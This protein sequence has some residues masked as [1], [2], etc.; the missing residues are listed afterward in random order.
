MAKYADI[1]GNY[2]EPKFA[3]IDVWKKLHPSL[4]FALLL[5]YKDIR[6]KSNKNNINMTKESL[7]TMKKD[8]YLSLEFSEDATME[9]SLTSEG[10]LGIWIH[11]SVSEAQLDQIFKRFSLLGEDFQPV[12]S[13]EFLDDV[14]KLPHIQVLN[15]HL[16]L[17][18]THINGNI[19]FYH[20]PLFLANL[21]GIPWS[22]LVR[23]YNNALSK[24]KEQLPF[25]QWKQLDFIEPFPWEIKDADLKMWF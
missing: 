3:R 15:E 8:G 4:Q 21:E 16:R 23:T 1:F 10:M 11:P 14:R 17:I 2:D 7:F 19:K 24:Y 5:M 18:S 9:L 22:N 25:L 6:D 20:A 13:K 12:E